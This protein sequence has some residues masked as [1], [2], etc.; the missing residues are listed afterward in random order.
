VTLAW[1]E[2]AKSRSD[3]LK[4]E[5]RIKKLPREGKLALCYNGKHHS[6]LTPMAKGNHA[7]Q[8]KVKKPKKCKKK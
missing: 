7:Q 8:K 2:P 5:A 6:L 4:R 3:A 1:S